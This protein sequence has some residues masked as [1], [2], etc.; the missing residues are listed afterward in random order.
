MSG[1]MQLELWL[2]TYKAEAL[3]SALEKQGTSI[4]RRMQ[5]MLD[6]L[7]SELVPQE[8]QQIIQVRI[9]TE[10]AAQR[11]EQEAAR[12]YTAFRVVENG[13]ESFF[14]MGGKGTLLNVGRFLRQYLQESQ[15][16]V[17][18][19]LQSAFVSLEPIAAEQYDRLTAL[20]K[21]NP[22]K[23]PSMFDLDFDKQEVSALGAADG[24]K[25]YSMK[26]VS[27]AVYY[28]CRK[29]CI[30][31]A[32]YESR[33]L[34]GLTGRTAYAD[35]SPND[36]K[37]VVKELKK[38]IVYGP[39][40]EYPHEWSEVAG[41][42]PRLT[43]QCLTPGELR[44]CIL[45]LGTQGVWGHCDVYEYAYAGPGSNYHPANDVQA[46]MIGKLTVNH[47]QYTLIIKKV[48]STNPNK[49]LSGARF[50]VTSE[51]G[52]Y[53]KEVVTGRDG[54]VTLFPLDAGTYAVT[55]LEAPE[56]YEIDNAGPQ[57]VVLP[58]G[59]DKT[60]TVTFTDT[61]EITGEGSIRTR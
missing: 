4:E 23:V 10:R 27:T 5:M 16:P 24:W 30:D 54:T 40:I 39:G 15:G 47:E 35:I 48:D 42:L 17:A 8:T 21:E 58:N 33:L 34:D 55:E 18:T 43:A 29:Y 6:D 51:N 1:D 2:N 3:S 37:Q 13:A 19:A 36:R 26:A 28:A 59:S 31:P 12:R 60:V 7:Y 44:S 41:Y 56:G 22:K 25:T 45:D 32:Q 9:E 49:T 52:S 50:K 38:D 46:I 20:R 14:Q 57:Y 11:A 53:S 61:P